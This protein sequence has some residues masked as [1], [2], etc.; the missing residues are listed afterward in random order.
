MLI[1]VGAAAVNNTDVSPRNG[2]YST[3]VRGEPASGVAE[4]Y[5]GAADTD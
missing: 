2:W 1:R 5:S 4:G 3:S